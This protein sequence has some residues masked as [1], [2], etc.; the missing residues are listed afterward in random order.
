[1]RIVITS[2][3]PRMKMWL[4]GRPAKLHRAMARS[5]TRAGMLVERYSKMESPVDTGR[6]R[7]SINTSVRDLT[8]TIMPH[9]NYAIFVHDGTRY[10]K[11][12]P[13]MDEGYNMAESEIGAVFE[14]NIRGALR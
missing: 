11:A 12:R 8:A 14:R 13:F 10:M 5:V 7:A 4:L 2:N 1:M 9:V 3:I 6:M